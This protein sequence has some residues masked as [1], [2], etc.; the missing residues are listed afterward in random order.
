MQLSALREYIERRG[1]KLAEEYIDEG[2]SGARERRPALDRL[3]VGASRRA[4]DAVVVFR[5]D[6]FARSVSR[7]ARAFDE[8]R[9]LGIEFVSLHEAV[10]TSTPMGRAMFHIAG[11][12]A[13][14]EREIIRERV[15]AGLANARR[16]GRKV[17]RPRALSLREGLARPLR[18]R[19]SEDGRRLGGD[20]EEDPT[21]ASHR[22]GS[23]IARSS[24]R[25]SRYC[26]PLRL[27][28]G[29]GSGTGVPLARALALSITLIVSRAESFVGSDLGAANVFR[30][31]PRGSSTGC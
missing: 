22:S 3:M 29:V 11:A 28:R 15:K 8:F 19:D 6:R 9:A 24:R 5:F 10:D 30:G 14:L 26:I 31:P 13:E 27:L 2:V 23:L 17:G 7:L 25:T 1:W 21:V 18:A 16:R 4:F 20:G 12:F